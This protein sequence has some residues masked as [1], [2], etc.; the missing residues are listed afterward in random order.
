MIQSQ[1]NLIQS[2]PSGYPIRSRLDRVLAF[3]SNSLGMVGLRVNELQRLLNK[4]KRLFN[5]ISNSNCALTNVSPQ[6]HQ[7]TQFSIG[8]MSTR[9]I[10]RQ[11]LIFAVSKIA[12]KTRLFRVFPPT[13]T[14]RFQSRLTYKSIGIPNQI[15]VEVE[16]IEPS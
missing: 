9:P 6:N 3:K 12:R 10:L 8:K 14:M 4:I 16:P 7:Q 5:R 15:R 2:H 13:F 11:I 1:S